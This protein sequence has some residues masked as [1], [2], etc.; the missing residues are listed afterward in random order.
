MLVTTSCPDSS[1]A[2]YQFRWRGDYR[3]KDM[4]RYGL[5]IATFDTIHHAITTF[6]TSPLLLVPNIVISFLLTTLPT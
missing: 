2:E 3:D 4:P 5:S 1:C 6:V